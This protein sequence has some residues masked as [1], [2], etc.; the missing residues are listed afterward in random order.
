M[1]AED[2]L[3]RIYDTLT[4]ERKHDKSQQGI[5]QCQQC[6]KHTTIAC[7]RFVGQSLCK[8]LTKIGNKG[9]VKKKRML[10]KK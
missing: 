1:R 5:I 7:K 9:S 6:G 10:L 3:G 8:A 2:A 4:N